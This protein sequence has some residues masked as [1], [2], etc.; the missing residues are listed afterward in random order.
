M[1][2]I[3]D[4]F[5]Q[6]VVNRIQQTNFRKKLQISQKNISSNP[7]KTIFVII[8]TYIFAHNLLGL[9][10][11]VVSIVLAVSP[12]NYGLIATGKVSVTTPDEL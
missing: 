12:D 11:V 7:H 8:F 6:L 9:P 3:L 4:S 2:Q 1:F 5:R 10:A